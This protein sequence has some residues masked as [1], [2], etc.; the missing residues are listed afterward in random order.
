MLQDWL[1]QNALAAI[2][3]TAVG[4]AAIGGAVVYVGVL[5]Q[6]QAPAVSSPDD[7]KAPASTPSPEVSAAAPDRFLVHVSGNLQG[8]MGSLGKPPIEGTH[9][10]T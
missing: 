3:G 8:G 10:F 9:T 4:T 7:G 5:P 6:A 1:K 2:I